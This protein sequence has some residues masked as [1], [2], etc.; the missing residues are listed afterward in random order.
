MVKTKNICSINTS[1]SLFLYFLI[2]GYDEKDIFILSGGIPQSTRK[3]INH[4]YFPHFIFK[5]DAKEDN[6]LKFLINN[7]QVGFMYLYG[8]IKLRLLLFIKTFN[9]NVEVY[10]HGHTQFSYMFYEYENSYIIEDGLINYRE[11][12]K[13]PKINRIVEIILHIFG[14]YILNSKEGYGTHENV[15]KVY[16]TRKPFPES[17]KNKA[18]YLDMQKNW[19]NL[20]E[21]EKNNILNI[22]NFD[23]EILKEKVV[24]LLTQTHCEDG[25]LDYKEEI[26]IYK[27]I[28]RNNSSKNLV[29][30]PHPREVT[31]Y[32]KVFPDIKIINKDFPIEIMSLFDNNIEKIITINSTAALHFPKEKIEIYMGETSSEEVNDA[33]DKL[34]QLL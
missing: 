10:G 22:F 1:Y 9:C 18:E 27:E 4:I 28:V 17:V 11:L 21:N 12:S 5:F 30:K 34:L 14:I 16:L 15:K 24:V 13:T 32:E 3:N 6:P 33:R 7:P 31:N 26:G 23:N 8:I 20:P 29:I 2:K 19:D 25:D